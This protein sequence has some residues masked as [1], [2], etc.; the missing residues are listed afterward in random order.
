V[1]ARIASDSDDQE[2]AGDQ[3]SDRPPRAFSS[4]C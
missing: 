4:P 3:V 1:A 2:G